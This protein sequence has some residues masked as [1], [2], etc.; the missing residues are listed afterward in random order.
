VGLAPDLTV[1]VQVAGLVDTFDAD[2]ALAQSGPLY[3]GGQARVVKA[4]TAEAFL[5]TWAAV[6]EEIAAR[7]QA[8]PAPAPTPSGDEG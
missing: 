3:D 7:W 6:G 1:T 2:G 5:R 4:R 8:Q